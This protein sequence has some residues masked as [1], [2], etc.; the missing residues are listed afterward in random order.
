MIVNLFFI[1]TKWWCLHDGQDDI[2]L[3]T[4]SLNVRSI[5]I[6]IVGSNRNQHTRNTS[7]NNNIVSI[8]TTRR[9][10]NTLLSP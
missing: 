2:I 6:G 5:Y 8:A 7:R 10:D 1:T 9:H 3:T 4:K